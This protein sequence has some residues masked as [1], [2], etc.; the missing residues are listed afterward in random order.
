MD[1]CIFALSYYASI[2]Q[3]A[4]NKFIKI[5]LFSTFINF[6]IILFAYGFLVNQQS[7]HYLFIFNLIGSILVLLFNFSET[8]VF[9]KKI[10]YK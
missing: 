5:S 10:R 1:A 3:R 7:Y 6:T 2:I 9:I 8:R 4:I